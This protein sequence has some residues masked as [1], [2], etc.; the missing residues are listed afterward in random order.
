MEFPKIEIKRTCENIEDY[1]IDDILWKTP[2]LSHGA[3]K[4][5]MSA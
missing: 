2:Y 1:N 5:N 3:I 4:M